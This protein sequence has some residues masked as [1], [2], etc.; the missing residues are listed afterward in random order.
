MLTTQMCIFVDILFVV[1]LSV[2][3]RTMLSFCTWC[4][5]RKAASWRLCQ[6][7]VGWTRDSWSEWYV[8]RNCRH[9][10]VLS[11]RL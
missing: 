6:R 3:R 2:S 9:S 10:R 11:L 8:W 1:L 5:G 7:S 4:V